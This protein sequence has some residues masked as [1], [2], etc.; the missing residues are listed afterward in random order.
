MERQEHVSL[1][2]LDAQKPEFAD[3]QKDESCVA[4]TYR[5]PQLYIVGKA[6]DLVQSY[7]SGKYGD[8][9]TSY[10]WNR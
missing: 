3:Q 4:P 8:G 10:N 5:A 6:I 1:T 2:D 9:Y 7:S